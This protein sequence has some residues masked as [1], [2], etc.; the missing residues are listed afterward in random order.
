MFG[1]CGGCQFQDIPYADELRLKEE[2]LRRLFRD[3]GLETNGAFQPIVPSPQEYAY[4]CRLDMKFLKIKSGEMF[5]GFSP[6][7]GFRVVEVEACPIAMKAVSDFLPQLRRQ[8]AEKMPK[9]Y[10]NANLTVKTGDDGRV[11]WGGIGRRS[12]RMQPQDYL[13]TDIDGIRIFYSLDTF[14]Q[15]NFS[16]L[17]ALTAAI[18]GLGVFAPDRIF[19]DLYGGVGLFGIVFAR[20]VKQ[21]FLIEENIHAIRC[22]RYNRSYHR[23]GNMEILEGRMEDVFSDLPVQADGARSVALVDPPRA[24]LSESVCGMLNGPTSLQTL[25]YLSCH[26]QTLVRDLGI[27]TEGGWRAER[28]IPF[29]FFP[30]TRHVETLVLLQ[31]KKPVL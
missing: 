2:M 24:G 1:E 14:F 15:A 10:R 12:L 30:K 31:R 22:A 26:P 16:I 9:K 4:R 20:D 17:P 27:L 18:R 7:K 19:F 6:A 11:F 28:I 13:W 21:V 3:S 8:A 25:V 23:I 29:D 5:M